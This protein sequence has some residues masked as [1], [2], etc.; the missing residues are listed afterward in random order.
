MDSHK[1]VHIP[2]IWN[3]SLKNNKNI[4]MLQEH[5]MRFDK[6][7]ADKGDLAASVKE[8]EWKELGYDVEGKTQA[9]VFDAT[10]KQDRNKFMF[11]QYKGGNVDNHSVGMRY[12]QMKMA[13]NSD[14]D[15]YK[16]EKENWDKYF[17]DIA[18][19]KDAEAAGFFWAVLEAK[20]IEGSAVVLGSNTITP[21]LA[22]AKA[23]SKEEQTQP[24]EKSLEEIEINKFFNQK[25]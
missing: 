8:Y 4:K 17:P 5:E 14:K 13:I 7:I 23:H 24:D 15:A 6:V 20:A 11:D 3:R 21:T 16:N 1:D 25:N 22:R 2:G 12:V 18:N 10:V 19:K 9:L